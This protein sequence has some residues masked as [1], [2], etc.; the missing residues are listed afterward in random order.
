MTTI[1]KVAVPVPLRSVFDYLPP[2]GVLLEDLIPGQRILIPFGPKTLCGCLLAIA[3]DTHIDAARLKAATAVLDRRSLQSES[4]LKLLI[5]ASRYYHHPIGEVI[6]SAFPVLLRKGQSATGSFETRWFAA[7]RIEEIHAKI[8]SRAHRQRSLIDLFETHPEGVQQRALNGLGWNWRPTARV[9]LQ[10]NLIEQRIMTE[11]ERTAPE[12]ARPD[13][14]LNREQQQA[15]DRI[16]FDLDHFEIFLLEGITGSGK[17]EVYFRVIET[18]LA[19]RKQIM[20]LVPE[21]TL[22]PQLETRFESRFKLPIA[23]FHS[24]LTEEKRKNSWLQMVEGRSA[25]LLGTRSAVFTPL[26]WPGLI[27]LDE[28]HDLSFKQQEGFRFSARDIAIKRAQ[29]LDIPVVLG[30]ATPSLESIQ[31]ANL[32]RYQHLRLPLRTGSARPPSIRVLDIRKQPLAGG[33]APGLVQEIKKTLARNEQILLFINRRGYAPTLIC[34]QCGEVARCR[35]CDS[36]LVVHAES[37]KLRCHHCLAERAMPKICESCASEKLL[38]LGLGTERVEQVLEKIFPNAKIAR[39]DRD[40]TRRKGSLKQALDH[41]ES[42]KTHILVGT[43]ML[44]KG[45]HFPNVTLVGLL[46]T[47]SGLFSTDFRGTERLAQLIV[48]VAGRAGRARKPGTVIIQTRH[49]EHPLLEALIRRGYAGFAKDALV[50]RKQIGLPPFSFQALFRAEGTDPDIAHAFLENIRVIAESRNNP[51]IE[52]LGPAPA[53][54]AKR[55][56]RYRFQLLFQARRRGYLHDHLGWLLA[57]LPDVPGLSRVRWSI[58]IDPVNL[59]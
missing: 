58:D 44:A 35:R 21:I 48:Q 26:K 41:I 54:M 53:P 28:E 57:R 55:I 59:F 29:A 25:I 36:N 49:P 38:A 6:A 8:P 9:L 15:V 11:I 43:Q 23:I 10:R 17:T 34:H 52:I 33:L 12:V 47:D 18:V 24:G 56:G 32:G 7:A 39:I 4:D 45:H 42:G 22:T 1:L 5:W 13:F 19:A 16:R 50:E 14:E 51:G 46:D 40:S 3:E 37:R 27:I 2:P 31:N 30:S 20:V